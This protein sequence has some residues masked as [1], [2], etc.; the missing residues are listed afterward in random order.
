MSISRRALLG[1]SGAGAALLVPRRARAQRGAQP[2]ADPLDVRDDFPVTT[3]RGVYLDTAYIGPTPIFDPDL[4]EENQPTLRGLALADEVL[5]K[6]Y[7]DNA[8]RFL[9]RIGM[10]FDV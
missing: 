1:M 6:L 3:E 5:Q 2:D 9:D 7:H 10:K 8:M 4:P